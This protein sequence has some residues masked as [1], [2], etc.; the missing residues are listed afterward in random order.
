MGELN[1]AQEYADPMAQVLPTNP[2]SQYGIDIVFDSICQTIFLPR[3]PSNHAARMRKAIDPAPAN[4]EYL[5]QPVSWLCVGPTAAD[6][7]VTMFM[8]CHEVFVVSPEDSDTR[9][10]RLTRVA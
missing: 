10:I 6:R 9:R 7:F 5:H 3:R 1:N 2:V 4:E 8:E